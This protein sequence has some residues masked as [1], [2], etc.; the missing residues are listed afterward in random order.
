MEQ[1][2]EFRIVC[3]NLD[4][5]KAV[6]ARFA[7]KHRLFDRQPDSVVFDGGFVDFVKRGALDGFL[8]A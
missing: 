2:R 8:G 1:L 4:T 6:L 7:A 3:G 5:G